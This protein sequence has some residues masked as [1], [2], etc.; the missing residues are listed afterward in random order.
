M[1]HSD[2]DSEEEGYGH[3]AGYPAG[4][5][6]HHAPHLPRGRKCQENASPS[7]SPP[8]SPRLAAA[9]AAL[10]R[11]TA[12]EQDRRVNPPVVDELEHGCP[13]VREPNHTVRAL[14]SQATR[15]SSCHI[16]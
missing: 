15:G 4:G 14:P 9:A 11:Y 5:L 6:P 3:P 13:Q 16:T 7:S 12:M 1:Y 2:D 8:L 10:H